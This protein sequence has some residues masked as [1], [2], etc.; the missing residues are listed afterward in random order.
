V[1]QYKINEDDDKIHCIRVA[2]TFKNPY[3]KMIVKNMD[4]AIMTEFS[5]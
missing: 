5:N 4:W 2:V 1:Y 3:S